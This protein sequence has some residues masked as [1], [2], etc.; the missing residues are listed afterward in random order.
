M[1]MI[2]IFSLTLCV[3]ILIPWMIRSDFQ[4]RMLKALRGEILTNIDRIQEYI[5]S[6]PEKDNGPHPSAG[7]CSPV[8]TDTVFRKMRREDFRT[9]V[10]SDKDK[11]ELEKILEY[12]LK[13]TGDIMQNNSKNIY[14]EQIHIL[15]GI[16]AK[17]EGYLKNKGSR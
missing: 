10:L 7:I 2:I 11:D 17:I 13:H 4:K 16:Q 6:V 9:R 5:R 8:L 15:E 14:L 12:N 3:V 1:D